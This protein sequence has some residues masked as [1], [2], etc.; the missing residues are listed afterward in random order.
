MT[1]TF[2]LV[3]ALSLAGTDPRILNDPDMK[4]QL[5]TYSEA[6]RKFFLEDFEALVA[7]WE[8]D[9]VR[10]VPHAGYC[11]C[12]SR[13]APVRWLPERP[14]FPHSAFTRYVDA[15]L[16]DDPAV[17]AEYRTARRAREACF[18]EL[19]GT[20]AEVNGGRRP[21][22]FRDVEGE[23]REDCLRVVP[24]AEYCSC[25]ALR[26]PLGGF[27]RYAYSMVGRDTNANDA[28]Y[29]AAVRARDVCGSELRG[30]KAEANGAAERRRSGV[31]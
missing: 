4:E 25:L 28:D 23:W 1:R 27:A 26:A 17:N 14:F 13:Q 9:C 12:L 6:E 10:V 8:E 5:D 22:R 16:E 2:V 18:S 30:K 20:K 19:R 31:R 29:Q 7:A 11:S 3:A 24:H 15:M 21:S